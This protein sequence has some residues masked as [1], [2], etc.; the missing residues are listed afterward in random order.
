VCEQGE[1]RTSALLG[2][3]WSRAD[4]DHRH[5]TVVIRLTSGYANSDFGFVVG[6]GRLRLATCRRADVLAH[7]NEN[8]W[9]TWPMGSIV[10]GEDIAEIYDATYA[11]QA[12]PSVVDPMVDLLAQLA[13]A[14]AALEFAVGT[15]RIALP[16]S[17][18]G[19]SVQGIELSPDMVDQLRGKPGATGVPVTIGDMTSTRLPDRFHL[20][21]LVANSIMNVTTQEEQIA[22]FSNAADHL[23]PGGLFVIELMVPQIRRVPPT[24]MAR[25]FALEADHVGIETFD[26]VLGQVAWSHHWMEV[27]GRLVRHSAPYRYI[28]PS[29]LLLMAK[30]AGFELQDRWGGWDRSPFTSESGGQVTV[31]VKTGQAGQQ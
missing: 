2:A 14:G 27:D 24:E 28:W 16:L 22:V 23:E 10:W 19:I 13:G 30:I 8:R 25:V 11:A 6:L 7:E 1:G 15:G 26:D 12:E 9:Q 5:S 18:R 21:Y 3:L 20:V 4:G 31:F 17:R 29:E